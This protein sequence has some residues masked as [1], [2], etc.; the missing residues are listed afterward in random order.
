MHAHVQVNNVTGSFHTE[1]EVPDYA[2]MGEYLLYIWII[3]SA[4]A[5]NVTDIDVLNSKQLL[6]S[7]D[8]TVSSPRKPTAELQ[9]VADPWV[10]PNGTVSFN[11]T[12]VSYIGASVGNST[13]TVTWSVPSFSGAQGV[14]SLTTNADGFAAGAIDL[15]P[16]AAAAAAQGQTLFGE[17]S[18]NVE[19]IGP[20]RERITKSASVT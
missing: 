12:A 5:P 6:T 10:T 20:T 7:V 4:T 19:W 3:S 2:R 16:A 1:V 9:L 14:L 17:V 13:I 8:F 11:A 15:A 18:V